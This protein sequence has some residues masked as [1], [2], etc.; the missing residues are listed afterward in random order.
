MDS[1]ILNSL[2]EQISNFPDVNASRIKTIF[3]PN[4]DTLVVYFTDDHT[5]TYWSELDD[6]LLLGRHAD[7]EQVTGVMVEYFS[8]WLLAATD[9]AHKSKQLVAA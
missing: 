5:P 3:E 1:R 4:A 2:R 9:L 8:E 6:Y 7:T